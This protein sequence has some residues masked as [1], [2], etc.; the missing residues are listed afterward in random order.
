MTAVEEIPAA[1]VPNGPPEEMAADLVAALGELAEI[2]ADD[3]AV[4]KTY[5]YR[6]ASLGAVMRVVRPV[7]ARHRLGVSQEVASSASGYVS[8]VTKLLHT[9][10]ALYVSPTLAMQVQ[11]DPQQ[12][13]SVI[14]YLRR[15]Q[16][17]ALL[18]LA[19]EDDDG[20]TVSEAAQTQAQRRAR[21]VPL[22]TVDDQ[23]TQLFADLGMTGEDRRGDRLAVL[24]DILGRDVATTVGMSLA[25]KTKVVAALTERARPEEVSP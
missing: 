15:Y 18:G 21:R 14:T 11:P 24:S 20:R 10:G 5:S 3:V 13:G 2:V 7:L 1:T 25:D 16:L 9:S 8:V 4:T 6:Y 12:L 22:P 17:V 19:V 23:I